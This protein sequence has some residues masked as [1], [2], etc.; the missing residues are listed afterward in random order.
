MLLLH[1]ILLTGNL[2]ARLLEMTGNSTHYG[3]QLETC[4]PQT[5]QH[6]KDSPS[7]PVCVLCLSLFDLK[8]EDRNKKIFKQQTGLH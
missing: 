6:L 7:Q 5:F 2:Q 4:S 3:Y 8:D 1:E